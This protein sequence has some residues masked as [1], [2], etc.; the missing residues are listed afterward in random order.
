MINGVRNFET[1]PSTHNDILSLTARECHCMDADKC[2]GGKTP[3]GA[4]GG[5]SVCLIAISKESYSGW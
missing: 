5:A 2:T 1:R 4:M 3:G